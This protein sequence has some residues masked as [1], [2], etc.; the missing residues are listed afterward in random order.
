[1][2]IADVAEVRV[3]MAEPM[4]YGGWGLRVVPGATAVMIR[5]G[6]AIR[7]ERHFRRALIITVDD[8]AQG[9]GVLLTH[10]STN[11]S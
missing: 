2:P 8:A 4:S 6:D 3:E 1:M 5:R 9:A 7:V 11:A 10:A